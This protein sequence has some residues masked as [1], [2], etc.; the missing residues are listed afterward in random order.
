MY[1]WLFVC[2]ESKNGSF[3]FEVGPHQFNIKMQHFTI[4]FQCLI[5]FFKLAGLWLDDEVVNHVGD[6]WI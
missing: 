4:S 6:I 2:E 3:K 1:R 5:F